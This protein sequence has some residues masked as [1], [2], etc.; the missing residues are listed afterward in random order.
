MEEKLLYG[1][2]VV[3]F[4]ATALLYGGAIAEIFIL[5]P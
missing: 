4:G 5:L 3:L 1:A 2:I